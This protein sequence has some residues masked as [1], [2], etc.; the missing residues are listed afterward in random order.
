MSLQQLQARLVRR[1]TSPPQLVFAISRHWFVA[2]L[3]LGVGTAAM[4]AKVATDP[5]VYSGSMTLIV[6]TGENLL[7][8][9]REARGGAEAARTFFNSRIDIL[10]S[11]AVLESAVQKLREASP[12]ALTP[13]IPQAKQ[14]GLTGYLHELKKTVTGALASLDSSSG[15][16]TDPRHDILRAVA[17]LRSRAEVLP[18]PNSGSVRVRILHTNREQIARELAAWKDA[19]QERLSQMMEETRDSFVADRLAYWRSAEKAA[20]RKYQEAQSAAVA[21]LRSE[22]QEFLD[23]S[24]ASLDLL[25]QDVLQLRLERS[26]R[27]R[28]PVAAALSPLP[29][30]A[31]QLGS[32]RA[33]LDR[34]RTELVDAEIFRGPES[35]VAKQLRERIRELET[36]G[37]SA[38]PSLSGAPQAV[39]PPE[40]PAAVAATSGAEAE[41]LEARY[42]TALLRYSAMKRELDGLKDEQAELTMTHDKRQVYE[43]MSSDELDRMQSHRLVQFQ[44]ADKPTVDPNPLNRSAKKFMLAGALGGLALGLAFAVLR[45]V[46]AGRVRF[47]DDVVGEFGIPVVGV[48]PKR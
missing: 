5:V 25:L 8:E 35:A 45:E 28:N 1:L 34:L 18:R 26:Y 33:V 15:S 21:R 11:D 48:I 9:T 37:A 3:C 20:E 39:A 23:V 22:T 29:S 42:R 17:Y 38:V 10:Q 27:E 16:S 4:C 12:F 30:A 43:Q 7:P 19:Y 6:D 40:A 32:D 36:G 31:P 13:E 41:E 24:L 14:P 44:L 46:L 2:L 47:K